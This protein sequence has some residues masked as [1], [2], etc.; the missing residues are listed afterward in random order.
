MLV[1]M[2]AW[3]FRSHLQQRAH[4]GSSKARLI[5]VGV[6]II[7]DFTFTVCSIGH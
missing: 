5:H 4:D 2:L 3:E 6:G 7:A 1:R